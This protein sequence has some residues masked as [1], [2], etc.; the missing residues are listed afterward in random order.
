MKET[1]PHIY[2]FGNFRIDAAQRLLLQQDGE[3]VS[4]TPRVFD[5]LLYLVRHGGKVLTKDE[6]LSAIWTDTIVEENN[7]NQNISI[8]RRVL[9]ES[10]GENRYIATVPGRGY[11]FVAKVCETEVGENGRSGAGEIKSD[12]EMA[13]PSA[14]VNE[15]IL[16]PATDDERPA[17]NKKTSRFW[18]VGV[19]GGIFLGLT[20]LGFY[21]WRGST[22]PVPNALIKSVAVLPFKPLVAE[23]RNEALELGMADTLINKLSGSEL[24]VRPI[25]AVRRFGSLEQDAV[26]AGR[27]LGVESIL[28][29][30]IQQW[31]NKIR[32]NV[33]LV[34][35]ADGTPLWTGTFDEKF[36]DIFVVQDAIS[37]KVAAALALKLSGDEQTKLEKRYTNNAEAY[38]LYLRGRY[39]AQKVTEPEVRQAIVFYEQAITLDPSYALAYAGKA[40]AYRTLSLTTF[41]PSN[42]VIPKSKTAALRALEIDDSL[43]EAYAALG[44]TNFLYD[45]NWSEA[46]K[47]LQ[48]ALELSPRNADVHRAYAHFLSSSGRHDEAIA[49]SQQAREIDPFTPLANALEGQFLFYG[50]RYDEAIDRLEKTLELDPNFWAAYNTLGRVYIHQERWDEAIAAL[51]KARELSGGSTEPVT[52]MGYA[53]AK[54]GKRARAQETLEELKTFSKN[55]YV[56]AYNFAMIYNGLGEREQALNYL[57]KSFEQREVQ[58]TFIKIDSRWDDLRSDARFDA[59][60]KQMNFE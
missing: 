22:R 54:S 1:G 34:K 26:A 59:L 15:L 49:Q 8:L 13:E 38:E 5:T 39:H 19:A 42:E 60:F 29:G 50:G 25:S 58:L 7:L 12:T 55:S 6:L 36:T 30:N 43:A 20:L 41:A 28:D 14:L 32:V 11:K 21:S 33:R 37:K 53:L 56:P 35:V 24:I 3:T 45:W 17:S 40:I 31:G 51:I 10:R 46:E 44:W 47:N 23:N 52:Q 57:E 2:E 48:K 18:L 16:E 4:L 27:E 9:G